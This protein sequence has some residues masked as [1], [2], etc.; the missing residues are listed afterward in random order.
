MVYP[1]PHTH[2]HTHTH[3]LTTRYTVQQPEA[4]TELAGREVNLAPGENTLVGVRFKAP[5]PTLPDY[6]QLWPALKVCVQC[7]QCVGVF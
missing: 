6:D 5:L 1:N 4:A 7:V 3:T 2:T